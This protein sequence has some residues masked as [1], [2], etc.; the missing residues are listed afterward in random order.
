MQ[1]QKE[2]TFSFYIGNL[3]PNTEPAFKNSGAI[4][5]GLPGNVAC[6]MD[7][8]SVPPL[9]PRAAWVCCDDCQKWR[10]IPAELADVI[11]ETNCRWYYFPSCYF[12]YQF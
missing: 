1:L 7:G 10:C 4:S 5:T 9:P 8:A 11:G 6:K 12:I 2:F 3:D